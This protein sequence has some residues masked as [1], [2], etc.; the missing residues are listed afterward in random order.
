LGEIKPRANTF[1]FDFWYLTPLSAILQPWRPVLM[2][3]EAGEN[4]RRQATI[5]GKLYHMRLRVKC[6]K[7]YQL[8]AHI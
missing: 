7:V 4:R 8:L 3:E 5:T 1:D 2:V 6:D